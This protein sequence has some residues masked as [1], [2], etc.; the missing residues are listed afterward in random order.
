MQGRIRRKLAILMSIMIIVSPVEGVLA[1][2]VAKEWVGEQKNIVSGESLIPVTT[3]A[4][5]NPL[6]IIDTQPPELVDIRLSKEE[7]EVPGTI[8]VEVIGVDDI[9]GLKRGLL[10][11]ENKV[12]NKTISI[13]VNEERKWNSETGEYD[14]LPEGLLK[15]QLTLDQYQLPGG[16]E[17]ES[18]WIEDRAGNTQQYRKNLTEWEEQQGYKELAIGKTIKVINEGEGFDFT[19]ST[20][21]PNLAEDIKNLP[22]PSEDEPPAR[23]G[24]N[25][26]TGSKLA[27]DVF[28][29]IAGENKKLVL[30]GGNIQ[31]VFN[32]KDI[33]K[34]NIKDIDLSV[35]ISNI[36]RFNGSNAS[37]IEEIVQDNPTYVLSFPS[38]GKLPGKATIRLKV[39]YAFV[40]YLGREDLSIYYF[41][42]TKGVLVSIKNNVNV[43]DD[44]YVEFQIDHNSDFLVTK[45]KISEDP[46]S[47]NAYL[48]RLRISD[49]QLSPRFKKDTL[50]YTVEVRNSVKKIVVEGM[51][52]DT[53][54]VV[55]GTGE[56]SLLVGNNLVDIVVTAAD[57]KTIKTYTILINRDS[58]SSGGSSGGSSNSG[59][60]SPTSRPSTVEQIIDKLSE[61]EKEIILRK[62]KE[63]MPYTSLNVGLTLEQLKVFTN[64]KF[65]AK[66]IQE[67]LNNLEL[68][69]M[70]GIEENMLSDQ[71]ILKKVKNASFADVSKTHWAHNSIKSAAGLG[72]VAGMPDGIFAP[73]A[74]L[75]VADTFAFL[76]RVL[77]FNGITQMKLPRSTVEKYIIDKEHWAFASMASIGSKLTEET[78]ITI[79]QLETQPIARALLAQ[80]LYE[81]TDGKL[82]TKKQSINFTD[83]QTSPYIKGIDY[84]VTTGLLIG[85]SETTMSPD[86]ELTRAE[87]MAVL[88]R[89]DDLLN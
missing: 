16:Y 28:E 4:A 31:W 77:L 7:V 54:A 2:G 71:I 55:T 43:S 15:G 65:S 47:T 75:Q 26:E 17:L 73:S 46:K 1:Q 36:D 61:E 22:S 52:E 19:T 34:D 87:L 68:L 50:N 67:I 18:L 58:Q 14:Y 66:E 42:A 85:T 53:K 25:Y 84:C 60:T 74:P 59:S 20:S 83:A 56:R 3:G 51:A 23:I 27:E 76:D 64:N 82:E 30:E 39:D 9:A 57:G 44:G 5:I 88:I 81:I 69:R 8:E 37:N 49:G 38:N 40:Q 29:A 79:N 32:G 13:W 86:K 10:Y 24:I 11:F 72:L 70:L 35:K 48:A 45:G 78:L 89:L 21:N 33:E 62:F 80:V 12:A 6:G 63:D 41:D